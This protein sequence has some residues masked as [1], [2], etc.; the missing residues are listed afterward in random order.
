MDKRDV[1]QA[2][3]LLLSSYSTYKSTALDGK[4]RQ[5]EELLKSLKI[6]VEYKDVQTQ[7]GTYCE[8]FST[9]LFAVPYARALIVTYFSGP[10][11][12]FEAYSIET[13]YEKYV[14]QP[15]GT[16]VHTHT[17][18]RVDVVLRIYYLK[19]QQA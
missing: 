1:I 13:D 17:L 9:Q 19:A 14:E 8:P 7:N 18:K 6:A 16:L 15:D 3:A 2:I 11:I 12:C 4:V 5:L 10:N